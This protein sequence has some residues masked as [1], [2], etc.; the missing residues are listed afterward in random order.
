MGPEYL[1]FGN[2]CSSGYVVK[3][4][5]SSVKKTFASQSVIDAALQRCQEFMLT[6]ELVSGNRLELTLLPALV[7]NNSDSL[8]NCYELIRSDLLVLLV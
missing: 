4:T 2:V 7:G 8:A 1:L 5:V 3:T 6:T